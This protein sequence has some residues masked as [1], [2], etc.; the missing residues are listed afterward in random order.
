MALKESI[1]TS[2]FF[3]IKHISFD[4]CMMIIFIWKMEKFTWK[5]VKPLFLKYFFLVHTTLHCQSTD[6]IRIRWKFSGSGSYQKGPDSNPD[7]QPC[8]SLSFFWVKFPISDLVWACAVLSSGRRRWISACGVVMMRWITAPTFS[9]LDDPLR[10]ARRNRRNYRKIFIFFRNL[11][12]FVWDINLPIL[13]DRFRHRTDYI[14]T[15]RIGYQ[16]VRYYCWIGFWCSL[17]KFVSLCYVVRLV[18]L[19]WT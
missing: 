6:R 14:P 2:K 19:I 12:F 8:F 5:C 13:L 11:F 16:T 7:P 3:H 15:D 4:I 18:V 9:P 17:P 1:Q 10:K